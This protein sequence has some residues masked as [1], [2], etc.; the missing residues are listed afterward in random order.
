M[1]D[2][3]EDFKTCGRK[4][5][6]VFEKTLPIIKPGISLISIEKEICR[7]I[8]KSKGEAA[9]KTVPNYFWASCINLNEGVVHGIPDKTVVKP[10]DLVSLDV[11]LKYKDWY[12][13]MAYTLQVRSS[14]S[15]IQNWKWGKF[16]KAGEEALQKAIVAARLGNRVGDISR[17]IQK[18]IEDSGYQ[19]V[20]ELT[21]HG[22]GRELHQ[23]PWIPCFLD[24]PIG[25]TPILKEGMSL[26]IEV[27][28]TEGSPWLKKTTDGWTIRTA[29][30]KMS[31]LFEKTILVAKDGAKVITPYSWGELIDCPVLVNK[32]V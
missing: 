30:G 5:S 31:A 10:G 19:P 17:A 12:T 15:K 32:Q 29:D 24:S 20:R 3:V 8:E 23:F 14:K 6:S 2:S 21:G 25:K 26:A 22:I 11:G 27:I 4:L 28:Y 16:L 13:D 7:L 18:T 9:F 1:I